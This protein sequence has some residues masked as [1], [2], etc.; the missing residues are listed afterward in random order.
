MSTEDTIAP[1]ELSEP[2]VL[3]LVKESGFPFELQVANDL[4][5]F[6]FDVQLSFR[7]LDR[8]K[9][10]DAELDIIAQASETERTVRGTLVRTSLRL[11]VECRDMSTPLVFFGL[12]SGKA[13]RG[14][15]KMD[16]DWPYCWIDTSRD[17]GIPNRFSVIAFDESRSDLF[18]KQFHYQFAEPRRFYTATTVEWQKKRPKVHVTDRLKSTLSNFGAFVESSRF[19]WAELSRNPEYIERMIGGN[20]TVELTFLLLVHKA[21][22]YQYYNENRGLVRSGHT[23]L[24]SRFNS[25]RGVQFF[26]VD[27]VQHE[28]LQQTITKIRN[29]YGL[30]LDHVLPTVLSSATT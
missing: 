30:L 18:R 14:A 11:A 23:S 21:K 16:P 10:R 4:L 29:T 24:F 19:T 5:R 17:S 22:Q 20:A 12:D 9:N 13:P 8:T 26:V 7:F 1:V 28:S 25:E 6:G 15:D 2:Q 27:F 3:D